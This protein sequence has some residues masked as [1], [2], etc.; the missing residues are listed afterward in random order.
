LV[1]ATAAAFSLTAVAAAGLGQA[2]RPAEPAPAATNNP[3]VW[4]WGGQPEAVDWRGQSYIVQRDAGEFLGSFVAAPGDEVSRLLTVRNDGPTAAELL[5]DFLAPGAVP[6]VPA[7]ADSPVRVAWSSADGSGSVRLAEVV[8]A[9]ET[10]AAQIYLPLGGT[11]SI[12]LG[13]YYPYDSAFSLA[14]SQ[15][16]QPMSFDVRLTLREDTRRQDPTCPPG[17]DECEG[18]NPPP[19]P[20]PTSTQPTAPPPTDTGQVDPPP[21]GNTATTGDRRL[22]FTGT[23]AGAV[24]LVAGFLTIMGLIAL[25]ARRRSQDDPPNP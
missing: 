16:G 22:P 6:T 12:R 13:W 19:G 18:Q 24:A 11:V 10:R 3:L 15:P 4:E 14:P 17:Q 2:P 1:L 21:S 9:G 23:M 25:A 20:T 7:D 5:V 8:A